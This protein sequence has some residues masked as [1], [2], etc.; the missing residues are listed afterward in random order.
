VLLY[1]LCNLRMPF[2]GMT[3]EQVKAKVIEG[4]YKPIREC[5]TKQLKVLVNECLTV[6]RQLRPTASQLLSRP[7]FRG[8]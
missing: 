2:T 8:K 5:Y 1:E 3:L 6:D 7:Y 4:R